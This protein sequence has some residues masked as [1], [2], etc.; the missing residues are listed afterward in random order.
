MIR[1]FH[2]IR[3][4]LAFENKFFQYARYAIGEILLIVVGILIAV[5]IGNWNENRIARK[6]LQAKFKAQI[7]VMQADQE[8]LDAFKEILTFRI[9][10]IEQVLE[11]AGTPFSPLSKWGGGDV[12]I[13]PNRQTQFWEGPFPEHYDREFIEQ[14]YLLAASGPGDLKRLNTTI[15][16]E[17]VNNNLYS[18]IEN[19]AQK[20]EIDKWYVSWDL[21]VSSKYV[22]VG[23]RWRE[24]LR[25]HGALI[26]DLASIDNPLR[27]IQEFPETVAALKEVMYESIWVGF[28]ASELIRSF[29]QSIIWMEGEIAKLE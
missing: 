28:L 17:L 1:L 10:S 6:E 3:R 26:T 16:E 8:G 22:E 19:T 18:G 14:T 15:Y 5:Q 27:L 25:K 23:N 9:Y 11:W 13:L 4:Q 7:E 21:E 24:A 29:D 12:Y 20:T 2:T